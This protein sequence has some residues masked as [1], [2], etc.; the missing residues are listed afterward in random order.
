MLHMYDARRAAAMKTVE[1]PFTIGKSS[2][3]L[4]ALNS[5]LQIMP[6][7]S[8]SSTIGNIEPNS[9][10]SSAA[11]EHFSS[12]TLPVNVDHQHLILKPMKRKRATSE[13]TPW[14]KEVSADS[15]SSQTIR[16]VLCITTS[17]IN[18]LALCYLAAALHL[19]LVPCCLHLGCCICSRFMLMCF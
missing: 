9:V 18:S 12:P 13:N 8:E 11:M 16:F 1:Q 19:L 6:A 15:Q 14:H 17:L 4:H 10:P 2:S 7:T 3:S 5:M